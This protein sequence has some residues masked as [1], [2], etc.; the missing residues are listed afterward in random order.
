MEENA[1]ERKGK[2]LLCEQQSAW[3]PLRKPLSPLRLNFHNSHDD[4]NLKNETGCPN[5]T[6]C[7]DVGLRLVC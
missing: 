3:R 7:L 5:R 6:A 2:T 4:T 1:K